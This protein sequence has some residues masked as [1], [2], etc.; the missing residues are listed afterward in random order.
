MERLGA[1]VAVAT[2]VFAGTTTAIVIV[3]YAL[4]SGIV[5]WTALIGLAAG[6]IAFVFDTLTEARGVRQEGD[7]WD[8][9]VK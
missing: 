6:I 5:G 7:E 4:R 9:D 2:A 3:D 8:N 1:S